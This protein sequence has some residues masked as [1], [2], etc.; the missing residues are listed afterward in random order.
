MTTDADAADTR[1]VPERYH[2]NLR[3]DVIAILP[4]NLGRVLDL[5]GGKGVTAGALRQMGRASETVVV[6]LIDH[7]GAPGVDRF[8]SGNL[9][10]AAFVDG[11]L[12]REAPFDTILCLDVLEHLRDPWE[13]VSMCHDAISPGGHIAISVPNIRFVSVLA[14]LVFK[15]EFKYRSSG[16]MD[17]THLRWFVKAS[18]TEM[19]SDA[20]FAVET[21]ASNIGERSRVLN[22]AT[23]G[24]FRPFFE[25]QYL[26][27]GRKADARSS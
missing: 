8:Y 2:S 25:F 22:A 3:N 5:G 4:A 7:D 18:A 23:F 10:D 13:I 20:G 21:V 9:D 26:L 24:M 12:S 15:G 6:D 1:V 17:R 14:P 27:L 19:L 16:V 11:I